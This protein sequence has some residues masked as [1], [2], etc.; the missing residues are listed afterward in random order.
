M[1]TSVDRSEWICVVG[2]GAVT[3]IG[4][5]AP[6][7]TAAAR[8]GIAGFEDHPFMVD[9]RDEPFVVASVPSLDHD[10]PGH[11]RFVELGTPAIHEAFAPIASSPQMHPIPTIIG[12][13][14]PRPGLSKD[15]ATALAQSL[16]N[17]DLFRDRIAAPSFLPNGHSA[18]LMAIDAAC[19]KIGNGE[20]EFCIAGGIDSYMDPET[21]EWIERCEQLHN[22]DNAWGFIPGEAAGFCLLTSESAALRNGL[23]IFGRIASAPT[24]TEENRIK[25]ETVCVGRGLT[26]AVQQVFQKHLPEGSLVDH[27]ICDLNGEAYRADEFGFMLA[28]TSDRFVDTSAFTSPADCWGDIGAA[29]GPLFAALADSLSTE[30]YERTA[31]NLLWTSSEGGARSAALFSAEDPTEK[32]S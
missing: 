31:I 16:L 10:L 26:T 18:G 8:A 28:R 3:P 30:R 11:Q 24:A 5:T 27:T 29:S 20:T 4:L 2:V 13:P 17:D 1:R 23:P 6:S 12:L 21:L 22:L 9:Q 19:Q 32:R 7:A 15:I 25:T 14:E